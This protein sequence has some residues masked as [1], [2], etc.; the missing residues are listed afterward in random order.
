MSYY[1][2]FIKVKTIVCIFTI[3]FLF[4]SFSVSS[5]ELLKNDSSEISPN[6]Q[7]FLSFKSLQKAFTN[8]PVDYTLISGDNSGVNPFTLSHRNK[9]NRS[10]SIWKTLN[11]EILGYF[12]RDN[13]GFDFNQD[14]K[15]VS[16]LSWHPTLIFDRLFNQDTILNNYS[17]MIA[18]RTR[19][20]G[21]KVS[22]LRLAPQE[23][24]RYSFVIARDEDTALPVELMV[25]NPS[26]VL[27]LK[28]TVTAIDEPKFDDFSYN[29][30]IFDRF[31]LLKKS[32]IKILSKPWSILNIPQE[33]ILV[34]EGYV[35]MDDAQ[36]PFQTYSDGLVDFRVYK[37]KPS[38][39]FVPS[40]S[41]GTLTVL[42]R[43][44][45]NHEYAVVGEVPIQLG[46]MVLK[47][48]PASR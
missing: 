34:D 40:A 26:G 13:G 15:A 45:I 22:M 17:C 32:E 6:N 10:Y 14:R 28:V 19:L 2:N 20:S 23:D 41:N 4:A 3:V 8:T 37:H 39:L 25:I 46:E 47:R 27:V 35:V 1:K 43:S 16:P 44:D 7:C 21:R 29:D 31:E 11:G 12:L 9:G 30:E 18:G 5:Q 42:R 33:F 24:L 48:I 38:S 36:V